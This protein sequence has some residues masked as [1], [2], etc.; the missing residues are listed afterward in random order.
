MNPCSARLLK[1]SSRFP[2]ECFSAIPEKVRGS[3]RHRLTCIAHHKC[4]I[5]CPHFLIAI[6]ITLPRQVPIFMIY[7]YRPDYARSRAAVN[8]IRLI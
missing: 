4:A 3:D 2:A 1:Y 6:T 5:T 8:G 7:V